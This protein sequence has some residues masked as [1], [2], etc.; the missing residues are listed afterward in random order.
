MHAFPLSPNGKIDRKAL[1][2]P[3]AERGTEAEPYVTPSNE[4]ESKIAGIWRELLQVERVGARDNF[5]DLGGH[6]LLVVQAQAKLR[7]ALGIELPV[8]KLFEYPTISALAG[9]L[10]QRAPVAENGRDRGRRKA[11]FGRQPREEGELVS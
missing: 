11:A 8:V 10:S 1:P 2:D 7:D 4:L 5:F 3:K 6:S 9:F